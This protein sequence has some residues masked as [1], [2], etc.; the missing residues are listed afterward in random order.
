MADLNN[1]VQEGF[2]A[3]P[4]T[5]DKGIRASTAHAYLRPAQRRANLK[6]VTNSTVTRLLFE[7]T[8]A[9]GAAVLHKGKQT[10]YYADEVILSAGSIGSPHLL[11]LSGIGPHQTLT[12]H[13]IQILNDLPGVGQ[14]LI[15][16]SGDLCPKRLSQTGL[17]VQKI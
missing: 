10:E 3:L 5:V 14:N 11:M 7:G 1:N 8:R 2:G 17:T 6:V 15:G 9:I 12:K 4:M 13:D 16:S